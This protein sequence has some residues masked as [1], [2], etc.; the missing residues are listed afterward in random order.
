MIRAEREAEDI[1]GGRFRKF[2]PAQ[3]NLFGRMLE[4]PKKLVE[5]YQDRLKVGAV[6]ISGL[7]IHSQ[8]KPLFA[9]DYNDFLKTA[10]LMI[11]VAGTIG[12]VGLG[13]LV[14]YLHSFLDELDGYGD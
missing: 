12:V 7:I 14:V 1:I 6:C 5:R 4:E 3:K 10:A 13:S 8:F 9:G 2:E 11:G